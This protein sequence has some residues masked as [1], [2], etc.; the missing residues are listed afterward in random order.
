MSEQDEFLKELEV[1][2]DERADTF[3]NLEVP[4][5]E[6]KDPEDPETQPESVKD[7]RHRRLEEKLQ[8]EREANIALNERL[9]V[10][11]EVKAEQDTE[12]SEYLKSVERIY[13]T[14]TPEATAATELLKTALKGAKEEAKAEALAA[15]REEQQKAAQEVAKEEQAIDSMLEELEDQYGIDLTS[16]S[17][18]ATRRAFLTTLEK[19]SPK[20]SDGNIIAYAD[21][22]GV[23]E[24]LQSK[25]KPD[26]R[27]KDLASR[28]M[29]Q[30][31][32]SGESKLAVDATERFLRENG[33]I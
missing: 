25:K 1:K 12:A 3:G 15:L 13:G 33:I 4:A 17:S 28:S 14:D 9:R 30:S 6:A 23:Y 7:R 5:E 2:A 10:L 18:E 21:P 31:G 20:D 16:K 32:A 19:M 22:H 24:Y 11:A 26:T 8:A 29:T 27:A